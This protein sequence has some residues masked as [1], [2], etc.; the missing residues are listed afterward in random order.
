[1]DKKEAVWTNS[2]LVT[3]GKYHRRIQWVVLAS[4]IANIL[5]KLSPEI[6]FPV[7]CFFA[8]TGSYILY[9]YL[10]ALRASNPLIQAILLWIP[11][12]GIFVLLFSVTEGNK[13]FKSNGIKVG[14]M[15]AKT[16]TLE[17]QLTT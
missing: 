5:V 17:K 7:F 2:D 14:I 12:V 1:M 9:K 6:G 10:R 4:I 3:L 15:G 13:V 8:V 11:L 16:S